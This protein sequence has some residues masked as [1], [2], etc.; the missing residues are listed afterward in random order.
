MKRIYLFYPFL[1]MSSIVFFSCGEKKEG[2]KQTGESDIIPVKIAAIS[3]L[4]LPD[5][6]NATGLVTTENTAQYS[7][8]IGGV[9]TKIYVEE[10]R[11]FH[12]GDLLATLNATEIGAGLSQS[13]LNAEKAQRDYN[14][15]VSL[16]KDSVYTL[17]QLQNTKTALDIAERGKEAVA[18]N[19]RY[20]RIYAAADG[21]VT[22]KVAN[23]G[24]VVGAGSPVLLINEA[25]GNSNY[26]L[27]VGV[28]DREWAAINLGQ[29]GTVILDGYPGQAFDAF[30]F[31]KSQASDRAA[32]AFQV[33]L[34][35]TL[36]NTQPAVGMFGKAVIH[37]KKA[38]NVVVIPYDALVEVDGDNAFVFTPAGSNSVKRRP[39]VLSGF[40]NHQAYVLSGISNTDTIVVSNSAFLNE[41]SIIKITR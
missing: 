38:D 14:R 20:S 35:I 32:G 39:V 7:F 21:F 40:D 12:K 37:T 1:T 25:A 10:G 41:Q 31:R 8:K 6:I 33:E 30:V 5:T 18:F 9:I 4:S 2:T 23:E 13:N 34:K 27:K 3:S 29:K 28:T 22:Q 19:E 15:A 17:E 36:H 26:L 11:F 24:E 16:Y